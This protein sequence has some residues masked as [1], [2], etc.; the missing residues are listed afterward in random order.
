MSKKDEFGCHE[1]WLSLEM[2]K[3]LWCTYIAD[4][5]VITDNIVLNALAQDINHYFRNFDKELNEII[6]DGNLIK[7]AKEAE[8]EGYI[9][10]KETEKLLNRFKDVP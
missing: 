5:P 3:D 7:E 10:E 1:V 9:G 4:H 6:E 2:I 8:K